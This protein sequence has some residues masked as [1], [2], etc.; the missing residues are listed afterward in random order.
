[1]NPTF[2]CTYGQVSICQCDSVE[3][4]AAFPDIRFMIGGRDYFI[5]A[6]D[7]VLYD[8]GKCY[9]TLLAVQGL[10][11]YIMGLNFFKN[12]YT[13]FDQEHMRVGFT[14]SK[15]VSYRVYHLTEEYDKARNASTETNST[16]EEEMSVIS[17]LG[18]EPGHKSVE[19]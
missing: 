15:R 14:P 18:L 1:M 6:A 13:V 11:F 10:N 8:W 12:Y 2:N 3:D 5:P 19:E 4:V 17:S 7:Y 16:V 9:N